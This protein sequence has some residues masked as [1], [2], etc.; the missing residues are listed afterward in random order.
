[1]FG[2]FVAGELAGAVGLLRDA[3]RKRRHAGEI[4]AMYVRPEFVRRGVGR[5]LLAHALAV[6]RAAGIVQLTL[7]VTQGNDAAR[8][9]Y[10][11]TGF[12]PFGVE[13]RAIAVDGTYHA[14][15]HMVLLFPDG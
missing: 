7:T 12:V 11:A 14:K 1:M 5:R 15:E 10:A 2:A 3:R 6:A 13:P 4:V 8:R 9:L